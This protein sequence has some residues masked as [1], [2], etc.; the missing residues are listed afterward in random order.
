MRSCSRLDQFR[1]RTRRKAPV[2]TL[3]LIQQ[4]NSVLLGWGHHYKKAHVRKLFHQLD[5]W[6]VR[7]IWSHRYKRW[8]C[9]GWKTLPESK[10]Y[11][12]YGL[13]NLI[14]LIPSLNFQ[15]RTSS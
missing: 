14:D 10:L 5:R 4:I 3:E 13:V 1:Q 6:V 8:R 15:R 2:T 9:Q 12:E 11:G 7:R